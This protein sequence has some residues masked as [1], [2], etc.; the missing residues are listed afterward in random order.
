MADI[1]NVTK[2]TVQTHKMPAADRRTKATEVKVSPVPNQN[3]TQE[4]RV[5]TEI[6]TKS[7]ENI[8]GELD[9]LD[10]PFNVKYRLHDG[11]DRVIVQLFDKEE[12]N[13]IMEFPSTKILDFA[14][15]V[16]TRNNSIAVDE[17]L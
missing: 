5:S 8:N 15:G 4:E 13:I 11:T 3:K 17:M 12:E 14:K 2:P 6:I 7:I 10:S 1:T 9:A 16:K